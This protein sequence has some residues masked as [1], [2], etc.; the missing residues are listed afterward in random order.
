MNRNIILSVRNFP[1]SLQVDAAP[2][3]STTLYL[4]VSAVIPSR[5]VFFVVSFIYFVYLIYHTGSIRKTIFYS[6]FPFWLLNVGREFLFV[7]VPAEAIRTPLYWEGRIIVFIF[8]PFFIV[9]VTTIVVLYALVLGNLLRRIYNWISHLS[10]GHFIYT[11]YNPIIRQKSLIM[12]DISVQVL[13]YKYLIFFL[14]TFALFFFSSSL[15]TYFPG[16]SLL[17]TTTEYSFLAWLIIAIMTLGNCPKKDVDKM[18]VTFFFILFTMLVL[19]AGVTYLQFFKRGV[20]GLTIEKVSTIPAFGYGADEDQLFF[21]P[22]G[23]SYHANSLANWQ[24]SLLTTII[25][26]WLTI[27]NL[28]PKKISDFIIVVSVGLSVSVITLTLSRSAYLSLAIFLLLQFLFNY[29]TTLIA[30]RFTLNYFQKLKIPILMLGIYF[31]YVISDRVFNTLFSLSETGGLTTRQTQISE[32]IQLIRGSPLL[33]VGNGMFISASYDFNPEG[34]VRFFPEYVHNGF[35]LFIAER[36][37]LPLI[38]YLIGIYY[39][40]K[41]VKEAL[42][43]KTVQLIIIGGLIANYAMMLF[44]P[45]VNM[46]SL[47]ILITVL[48][49]EAKSHARK[50]KEILSL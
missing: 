6:F 14:I 38:S 28:L 35:I 33:G 11:I 30:L 50:Y 13:G 46:F 40:F 34:V 39:L 16:L 18:L 45:F 24:V 26:L 32:A 1:S 41:S 7:A 20:I 43:S 23:L 4:L 19:E 9:S 22:V 25:L 3:V 15:S 8:S 21:R 17:Y 48:L 42:F 29:K 2:L 5:R 44:Q 27:K 36:G 47:N 12:R 31:I 10:V 49:I 37:L